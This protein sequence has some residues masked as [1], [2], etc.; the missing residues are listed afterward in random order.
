[1]PV[2]PASVNS[3]G[4]YQMTTDWQRAA[5]WRNAV[6]STG[7][8][9]LAGKARSRMNAVTHGLTARHTMLP[10]EDPAE[11]AALRGATFSSLK[12]Q[13]ALE[14][15]LV[16]RVVSLIWRLRRF[17]AFELALM[18]W[19]AHYQARRYDAPSDIVGSTFCNEPVDAPAS[20]L[21]DGLRLG[22]TIE[23][24]LSKDLTGKFARYET[25]MQRQLSMALKDL[26]ELQCPR[27][28]S[29]K[30]QAKP[31]AIANTRYTSP[32]HDPAYWAVESGT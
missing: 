23:A 10:G 28:E 16:E 32:E 21:Q 22:R 4:I 8:R 19:T 17:P 12:P 2:A 20:D 13:G 15:Q 31:K 9:S 26:R 1:M 30:E 5:N 11:F 6:L 7:P 25:A 24:L 18:E 29:Q 14:D 3:E 27:P